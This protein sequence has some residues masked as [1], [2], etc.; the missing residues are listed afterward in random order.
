MTLLPKHSIHVTF[1][2]PYLCNMK[3]KIYTALSSSPPKANGKYCAQIK[4]APGPNGLGKSEG[5]PI[6]D[7]MMGI[8]K[9]AIMNKMNKSMPV[10]SY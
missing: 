6:N 10:S 2:N 7:L 1:K 5:R 9:L 3:P 4:P 8:S